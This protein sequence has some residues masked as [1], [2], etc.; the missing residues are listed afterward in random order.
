MDQTSELIKVYAKYIFNPFNFVYFQY[1]W[2]Q[3]GT[4]MHEADGPDYWQR[5]VLLKYEEELLAR[6]D[7]TKTG[8]IRIAV[9]S[10]HGIGKGALSS[11]LID[12]FITTRTNPQIVV[13]ANTKPQLETK[14]WRELAKWTGVSKNSYWFKHTATAHYY[15]LDPAMEFTWRANAIPWNKDRS[16]AFAGTHDRSVFLLMDEASAI[17]K[18]IWEVSEGAMTTEQ[19]VHFALGN[20]TLATG[21]FNDCFES[22]CGELFAFEG[23]TDIDGML[24]G[25][26]KCVKIKDGPGRWICFEVDSRFAKMS[27]KDEVRGQIS[28]Y[29][30]DSDFCRV[31]VRGKPP[32]GSTLILISPYLYEESSQRDVTERDFYSEPKIMGVDPSEG[33]TDVACIAR[34][35][36]LATF[37]F[38][39]F[40]TRPER[41]AEVVIREI[42]DWQ[43]DAVFV[44][45]T[46]AGNTVMYI[47]NQR[48]Y[49]GILYGVRG[50]NRSYEPQNYYNLRT[51]EYCLLKDWMEKGGGLP[52]DLELKEE[53]CIHECALNLK[54]QYQLQDKREVKKNLGRSPNKADALALTFAG[55]V[56]TT[57]RMRGKVSS[58]K[59]D[60][61]ELSYGQ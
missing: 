8:A 24:T 37:P 33:G 46:G 18:V 51:E 20:P 10:G 50:G 40:S 14:T 17:D 2:G 57:E 42:E 3:K 27:N 47:L 22:D 12:H 45:E 6:L 54:D 52:K 5:S 11:W 56:N 35:Q 26:P 16:E 31:R 21:A 41:L 13:T 61:D 55:P 29:G 39:T 59:T 48:G 4:A 34:R 25:D 19:C 60:Y 36:G 23:P 32:R 53:L 43:P 7:G 1:P 49:S 30:I 58:Y 9:R 15:V 44:D 38:K 28:R